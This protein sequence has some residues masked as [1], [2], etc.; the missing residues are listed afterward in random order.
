MLKYCNYCSA[1]TSDFVY[2][3]F[4]SVELITPVLLVSITFELF[5]LAKYENSTRE[6]NNKCCLIAQYTYRKCINGPRSPALSLE[7]MVVS[8]A[9]TRKLERA[10]QLGL[11]E[12]GAKFCPYSPK[13]SHRN[14]GVEG[15]CVSVS[16]EW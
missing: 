2:I 6:A 7:I 3:F 5:F 9:E 15:V 8:T 13:Y 12:G 4:F 16:S 11:E 14:G 10:L 1:L